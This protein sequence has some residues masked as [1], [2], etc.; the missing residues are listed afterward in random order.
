MS[1]R[2]RAAQNKTLP[3]NLYTKKRGGRLYYVYRRPDTKKEHGFGYDRQ[4]AVDAANQLNQLLGKERNL[5]SQ[6]VQS[7]TT[8]SEYITDRYLGQ[9]LPTRLI[10]G[11]H[12]SV[13]TIREYS[14]ICRSIESELGMF[15]LSS[16]T[17]KQLAD[18][19]NTQSTNETFNKHRARLIDIYK[20]AVSDGEPNVENIA[21]RILPKDAE[22]V[23]R[24][25]LSLKEFIEIYNHASFPIQS[26]MELSLNALQRRADIQKWRFDDSHEDSFIYKVIQKTER[27]GKLSYIR[28]PKTLPLVYSKRGV[29]SLQELIDSCRD[30][31]PC[32]YLIHQRPKR[33]RPSTEKDHWFQLSPG[34]ISRGFAKA[35][36]ASGWFK[37]MPKELQP[38]FHEIISLGEHLREKTGWSVKEIQLLRGHSTEKMTKKYLEGHEWT[39]IQ[40]PMSSKNNGQIMD[41]KKPLTMR[42][43]LIY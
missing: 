25:R 2:R 39:T 27:H 41:N 1:P 35:R 40:V 43:L 37:H 34:Q 4:K 11:K 12:L 16:I 31:T 29:S 22:L 20:N 15:S 6:V 33:F 3:A 21:E 26:A 5:V 23:K 18:Y 13:H 36:E 14:R 7:G 10:N 30:D 24:Q 17:Q 38:T 42:G 8:L 32:P 19:L 28:I 9:I